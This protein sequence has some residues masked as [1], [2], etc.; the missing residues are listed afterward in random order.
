[1]FD[2]KRC[3]EDACDSA[4]NQHGFQTDINK[5]NPASATKP[6]AGFLYILASLP[7]VV[8]TAK[9]TG[10]GTLTGRTLS[11]TA[12]TIPTADFQSAV[13]AGGEQYIVS[14]KVTESPT[15]GNAVRSVDVVRV[16]KPEFNAQYDR[17]VTANGNGV[18]TGTSPSLES[19]RGEGYNG[20]GERFVEGS[21]GKDAEGGP[22]AEGA[23][24]I[25]KIADGGNITRFT[26]KHNP[27]NNPKV[28]A[29]AVED[30]KAIYGYRPSKEGSLKAFANGD[31]SN[32]DFVEGL[33]QD[34]ISYHNR[35]EVGVLELI[36]KMRNQGYTDDQVVR[37]VVEYRNQSRLSAY[38]DAKGNVIDQEGYA[39]ALAHCKTYEQLR[40]EGK[41]NEAIIKSATRGN[42]GM[43]A[44]T[45]LY[46][47]YYNQYAGEK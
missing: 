10:V 15:G 32:P 20:S 19:G 6:E 8:S 1:M 7:D 26:Y 35:N 28:L 34:R 40:A 31:W 30:P 47:D 3:F 11:G 41:T 45:G 37:A 33:R 22:G 38:L 13:T 21:N 2:K 23:G 4:I 14:F 5:R 25:G 12:Y 42:P 39:Q 29:D 16:P 24:D 9:F 44:S 17:N 27:S 18:P 36:T 43:D 46:D